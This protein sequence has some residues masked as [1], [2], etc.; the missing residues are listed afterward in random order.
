MKTKRGG[1]PSVELSIVPLEL[2]P[3][4]IARFISE[5]YDG[6]PHG[7][8]FVPRWRGPFLK[9]VIFDHPEF[10]P[11]HALAAFVG[12]RLVG[13]V[14]AQPYNVYLRGERTKCVF[15][16]WLA[17]APEGVGQ[18]AAIRLLGEM[19]ERLKLRGVQ[20]MVGIAYRSGPGVG[21]DFWEGYARAFP[22]DISPGRDLTYWARVLDGRAL[23]G[24]VKDPWLK[25]GGHAARLRPVFEPRIDREVRAFEDGDFF[26]CQ[27]LL[28]QTPAEITS[29][30]SLWEFSSAHDLGIGPQ[31]L[32][33]GL[34]RQPQGVSMFHVL[35]MSDAGPLKVGVVDHLITR[36][37]GKDLRRLLAATLWRLKQGGACLALV[38]R[39][40]GIA[41]TAMLL[42]GFV[43]YSAD[44]KIFLLPYSDQLRPEMPATFDLLVR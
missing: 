7:K 28:A 41:T 35:P 1:G 22:K 25:V 39:K 23:A 37:G 31:T 38:P 16:S 27:E 4:Q 26:G 12:D 34:D 20:F 19:K 11:D 9:H 21:L 15:G 24:A 42:A 17:I 13:L 30:P 2:E 8:S 36:K 3:A 40:P 32:V 43:P 6:H 44:F 14:M 5:I 18:F 33:L 29:A 10:T